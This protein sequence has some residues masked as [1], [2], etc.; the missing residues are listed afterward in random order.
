MLSVCC[1]V[2]GCVGRGGAGGCR[3]VA[4][5]V[6]VSDSVTCVLSGGLGTDAMAALWL[7]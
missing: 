3:S 5:L 7:C 4:L 6:T 2:Q 1:G